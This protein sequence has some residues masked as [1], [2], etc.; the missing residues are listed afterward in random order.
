MQ[1]TLLIPARLA[2]FAGENSLS[3]DALSKEI[4]RQEENFRQS[5]IYNATACILH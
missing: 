2:E 1:L 5:K 4:F 3:V